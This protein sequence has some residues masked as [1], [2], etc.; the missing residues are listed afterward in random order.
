MITIRLG[1]LHVLQGPPATRQRVVTTA[2]AGYAKTLTDLVTVNNANKIATRLVY[3]PLREP[4]YYI[5]AG[6]LATG[7]VVGS[8]VL[9]LQRRRRFTSA[10]TLHRHIHVP[11][12]CTKLATHRHPLALLTQR[13]QKAT[14]TT[15]RTNH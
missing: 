8:V 5:Y 2:T 7:L 9:E 4:P 11:V 10:T 3:D 13:R 6:S 1:N 14:A 12:L 15:H